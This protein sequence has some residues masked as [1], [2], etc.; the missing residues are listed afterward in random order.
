M[1][2]DASPTL[3]GASPQLDVVA[4]RVRDW[5]LEELPVVE[6][7]DAAGLARS[8]GVTTTPS[9]FLLDRDGIVRGRWDRYV[10]PSELGVRLASLRPD[11]PKH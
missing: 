7:H 3:R 5:G 6:D 2:V 9:V 1:V 8:Y 10:G 4:A 11:G